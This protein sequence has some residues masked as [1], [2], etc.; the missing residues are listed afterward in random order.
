MI[1]RCILSFALIAGMRVLAA[2]PFS[3][4][5]RS[6]PWLSPEEEQ[7]KFHLPPG[8]EIQLVASEPD[9]IKP[10]NMAFDARGRLWVT[11]TREYPYPAPLDKPD[12]D[13]I[14]ILEDMDGDGTADKITMFADGLNIPTGIYPLTPALSPKGGKSGLMNACVA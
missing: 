12:R 6:T 11:V 10:I 13:A 9:L 8:F 14:K 2:D 5:V 4:G 3:E 7:K 1:S